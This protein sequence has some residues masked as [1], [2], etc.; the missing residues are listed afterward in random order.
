MSHAVGRRGHTLNDRGLDAQIA[1]A[2]IELGFSHLLTA[3]D[4]INM[5]NTQMGLPSEGSIPAQA[6]ALITALDL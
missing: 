6:N 3:V 1:V 2:V 5:A 4:T